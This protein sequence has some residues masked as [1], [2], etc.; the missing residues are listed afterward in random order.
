MSAVIVYFHF[1]LSSTHP[2]SCGAFAAEIEVAT[3]REGHQEQRKKG[4]KRSNF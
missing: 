2:L 1:I 3:E 4:E